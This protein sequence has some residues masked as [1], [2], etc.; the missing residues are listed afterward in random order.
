MC[1][2]S[3]LAFITAMCGDMPC[4]KFMTRTEW[5][6][7]CSRSILRVRVTA[8]TSCAV[9]G[10]HRMASCTSVSV[11]RSP[12]A[13]FP[14]DAFGISRHDTRL[15]QADMSHTAVHV[16]GREDEDISANLPFPCSSNVKHPYEFASFLQL[17]LDPLL[18]H[19]EVLQPSL[20]GRRHHGRG[21]GSPAGGRVSQNATLRDRFGPAFWAP[22]VIAFLS[23]GRKQWPS[24]GLGFRPA[25]LGGISEFRQHLSQLF[26]CSG[27]P[28]SGPRLP[29]HSADPRNL[30]PWQLAAP[31]SAST[32]YLADR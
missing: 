29:L 27:T 12:V 2:G 6:H 31:T 8:T 28:F 18:L 32:C 25:E 4:S 3:R 10:V 11:C 13:K 7:C 9:L 22:R 5:T 1:A 30:M 20:Q 24:G 23:A 17:R 16:A 19:D 14:F 15:I 21:G 26:L